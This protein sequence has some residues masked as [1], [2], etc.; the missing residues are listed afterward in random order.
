M[1]SFG[2]R[3]G[4]YIVMN[5]RTGKLKLVKTYADDI[6]HGEFTYYW[7]N[8]NV[9]LKGKFIDSK[10]AGSWKNFDPN[11]ALILEENY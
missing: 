1:S 7:D 6:L 4:Q 2:F 8:G 5:K 11:G 9:R 3:N 10:R